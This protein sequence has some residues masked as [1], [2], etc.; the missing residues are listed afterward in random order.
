MFQHRN[1]G[2]G[3]RG[4]SEVYAHDILKVKA[5]QV[6]NVIQWLHDPPHPP[7]PYQPVSSNL[8]IGSPLTE[9]QSEVHIISI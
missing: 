2:K 9:R 5:V 1:L 6:I 4:R 3:L 7:S 8:T